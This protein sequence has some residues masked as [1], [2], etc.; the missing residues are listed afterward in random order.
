[1][2]CSIILVDF[3]RLA[4]NRCSEVFRHLLSEIKLFLFYPLTRSLL[5]VILIVGE[6]E[7]NK[8]ISKKRIRVLFKDYSI[9]NTIHHRAKMLLD[10][11]I[12]KVYGFH[13][14][15]RDLDY[16]IDSLDYAQGKL[17]FKEFDKI[18]EESKNENL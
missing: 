2:K 17:T 15:D 8:G 14:S 13:Y 5:C 16:I 11:E 3:E 18:M 6:K 7:M 9:I 1:M 10:R 4:K 12:E